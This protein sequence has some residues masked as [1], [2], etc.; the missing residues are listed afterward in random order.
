MMCMGISGQYL[1]AVS[2]HWSFQSS[3]ISYFFF[4]EWRKKRISLVS[5]CDPIGVVNIY[6]IPLYLL[7]DAHWIESVFLQF[8]ILQIHI[9]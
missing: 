1:Y 3:I 5:E 8:F 4:N 9:H 2:P 7:R 6:S